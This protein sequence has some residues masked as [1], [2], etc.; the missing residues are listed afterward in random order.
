MLRRNNSLIGSIRAEATV[1]APGTV[2]AQPE[3]QHQC[4]GCLQRQH[5]SKRKRENPVQCLSKARAGKLTC[6]AHK[7]LEEQAQALQEAATC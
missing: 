6:V 3:H 1:R 5:R 2:V 7:S 4:W